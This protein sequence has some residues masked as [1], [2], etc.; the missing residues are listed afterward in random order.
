MLLDERAVVD[1]CATLTAEHFYRERHRHLYG[2]MLALHAQ[3]VRVDPITLAEQLD[4]A[5]EFAAAGGKE[6]IGYLTDVVPTGENASGYAL[7]V[8]ERADRRRLIERLA[9]ATSELYEG[10]VPARDIATGLQADI[11]PLAVSTAKRGFVH[12]R[13][14]LWPLIE[15]IEARA[16]DGLTTA[17][18]YV[19]P[20]GYP[21]IDDEIAG[22][23]ERGELM[24]IAGVPGGCKTAIAMNVSIN[25]VLADRPSGVLFVS[26][27]MTRRKLHTRNL[28]TVGRI[29]FS[30][31]RSGHL[32]GADWPRI[33]NASEI[34]G[35]AP[36]WVDQTP[37]PAI[38][39][40][41]AK[42]RKEKAE[43]PEI[44][45]VVVDFISWCNALL[46]RVGG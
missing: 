19:V 29:A 15:S 28:A 38:D 41:L 20:T 30:A 21:E 7:I 37:T 2:A 44:A 12:A 10:K 5:G 40:I 46:N 39:H 32:D 36:L 13:E 26:A 33:A 1:M 24:V 31:L 25:R 27:E 35:R 23:V 43:H 3:G 16:R 14:D 8:R 4:G 11:L 22:G 9:A 6:Y 45:L 34:L 42:C 17:P 18:A